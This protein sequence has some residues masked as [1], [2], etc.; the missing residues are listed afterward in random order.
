[1]SEENFITKALND[2]VLSRRTFLK[3]SG[4]LG[5]TAALAGGLNYGL[6]TSA[7]AAEAKAQA[8]NGDGEWLTAA[9]WHNC[10]GRCVNKA[11]VVDGIVVRQK[12]DDTHPDSP[13]YPQQR[14]CAR[15]RSQ[16]QQVFGADR[17][18][19]PMKRKNW[20][21]GGG[22]KELRGR[23]EWVRI[24]WDEALDIV[25]S[26]LIRIKEKHGNASIF[27]PRFESRLL[28]AWGGSMSSWGV[29]SEGAWPL[30]Q[31]MMA[32]PGGVATNDRLD[33]RNARLIVFFGSNPSV[34]SAGNPCYNYRQSKESGAKFI[35][36]DPYLNQSAQS[37]ADE[38]IPV[39]PGTDTA[40]LLGMA[41]HMITNDLHDQVFLDNYTVGFDAEH[42]PDGADP[43]DNFKDYVL[44]TYDG[45]PKTP[46]WA[47]EICGTPPQTIRH[48]AQ[49]IASV[50]P[51]IWSSSWAPARAN[52]GQQYCQAFLT[53]GWMTG[54][55]GRSG[56]GICV[57]AHSGASYGG[58]SLVRSGGSGAPGIANPL[59]GGVSLGYGFSEPENTE[60]QGIAY[61]EM[62][63]AVLN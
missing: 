40:L 60:F 17:L 5:G 49:E 45:T 41:Y 3:W 42:M 29:T 31:S 8:S 38:W 13:D 46:E 48:F 19:Y 62:W 56:A 34:S 26:E 32:G 58:P 36:V 61:E 43:K 20:E 21:P 30:V 4:A 18:K 2:T 14:G 24:S 55:V 63:D 51:M 10:G 11:Y 27:T 54:N 1:M 47:A 33:Y 39:R 50:K 23:D 6:K 7:P 16:R 15:G 25:A 12:T 9:C 44:G 57:S 22:N 59:A 52:R 37:L 53:V 28:N 35:F